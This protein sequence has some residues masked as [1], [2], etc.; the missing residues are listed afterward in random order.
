MSPRTLFALVALIALA[1]AAATALSRTDA[2]EEEPSFSLPGQP[3]IELLTPRNGSRHHNRSVVVRVKVDNFTLAPDRIGSQPRL[4]E[5][6]IK[7][8]LNRIPDCVEPEKLREAEQDPRGP[9]R[10]VGRSFDFPEYSGIN[11][12][13]AEKIGSVGSY[14]PATEPH[15]LYAGLPPGFYRLVVTLARNDGTSTP[16]HDVTI[17]QI[18]TDSGREHEVRC[19][20][21][22]VPT[23]EAATRLE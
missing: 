4:G 22:K 8:S 14:S 1:G 18:L 10:L 5:G 20:G 11:G 15:I 3:N 19:K 13:L 12:L 7:F 17:F 21:R 9:G 23:R 6:Y 16:A 2:A